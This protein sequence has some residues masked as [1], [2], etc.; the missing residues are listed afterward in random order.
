MRNKVMPPL[1]AQVPGLSESFSK[2]YK[3]S[4]ER[5]RQ[6]ALN[7]HSEKVFDHLVKIR[8][9][10]LFRPKYG[11]SLDCLILF[12][13]GFFFGGLYGYLV[14]FLVGGLLVGYWARN[15]S[16]MIPLGLV[17]FLGNALG[18]SVGITAPRPKSQAVAPQTD[19]PS[20]Q[21]NPRPQY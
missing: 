15:G 1:A 6:Y 14:S 4:K 7:D 5:A 16:K 8:V 9:L 20:V 18:Y 2:A 21:S 13:G 11:L 10:T 3:E 17:E 19:K 12:V